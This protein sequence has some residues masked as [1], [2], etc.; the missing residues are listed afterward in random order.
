MF[1]LAQFADVCL[2]GKV[3]NNFS[4]LTHLAHLASTAPLLLTVMTMVTINNSGTRG[5]TPSPTKTSVFIRF[6]IK[7]CFLPITLDENEQRIG[8]RLISWRSLAY[9]T[10]YI[11]LG[12]LSVVPMNYILDEDS[13]SNWRDGNVVETTTM[14]LNNILYISLIF[15]LLLAK[16][17]NNINTKMVLNERLLFPKHGIKNIISFFGTIIGTVAAMIAFFWQFDGSLQ[18]LAKGIIITLSGKVLSYSLS[19]N[20]V[21]R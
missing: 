19:R 13:I 8:F 1:F 6:L 14:S 3:G 4:I 15:P 17:L 11:G 20:T 16:G 21:G 2:K 18:D 9:V 5:M 7:V 10:I 12:L